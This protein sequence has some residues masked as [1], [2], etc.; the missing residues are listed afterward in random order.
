MSE[1]KDKKLDYWAW[2][3]AWISFIASV[4]SAFVAAIKSKPPEKDEY[5]K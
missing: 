2:G 1:E 5:Y 4:A 3:L